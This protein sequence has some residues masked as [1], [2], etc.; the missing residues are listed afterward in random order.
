MEPIFFD[1]KSCG[2]DIEHIHYPERLA[3]LVMA[4]ALYW[5]VS[6]GRWDAQPPAKKP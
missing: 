1:F 2:F 3:R 6:T 5:A 4:L